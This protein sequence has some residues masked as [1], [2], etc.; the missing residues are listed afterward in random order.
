[1]LPSLVPG[2]RGGCRW[3]FRG[4]C[5]RATQSANTPVSVHLHNPRVLPL[6]DPAV[7][8]VLANAA[9]AGRPPSAQFGRQVS[10]S[11]LAQLKWARNEKLVFTVKCWTFKGSG[12]YK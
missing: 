2:L 7:Y 6:A 8:H 9:D 1:M 4:P 11:C 10:R 12:I 5:D 3:G